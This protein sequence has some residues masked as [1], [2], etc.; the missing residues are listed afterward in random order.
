MKKG[1]EPFFV[2]VFRFVFR[3]LKETLEAGS[4][5]KRASD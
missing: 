4:P 1:H 3:F 5:R 2:V